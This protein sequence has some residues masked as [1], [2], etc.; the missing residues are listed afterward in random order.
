[1]RTHLT[2]TICGRKQSVPFAAITHFTSGDKYVS[3]HHPGGELILDET[4]ISIEAEFGQYLTRTHRGILVK[5][6][7][8]E[9]VFKYRHNKGWEV[10][11]AGVAELIRVSRANYKPIYG[12]IQART[13]A[14]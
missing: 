11:L 14:A 8:I 4:L 13:L 12:L 9:Q 2:A 7:L 5:T 6:H 3:A 1:M 10:R